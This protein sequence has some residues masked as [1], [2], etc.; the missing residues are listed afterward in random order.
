[1]YVIAVQLA[2]DYFGEPSS[3]WLYATHNI[4]FLGP[5]KNAKTFSSVQEALQWWDKHAENLSLHKCDI[6][7][8]NIYKKTY[9]KIQQ[10]EVKAK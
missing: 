2:V 4:P 3:S 7:T 6:S 10:L 8:L 5:E 1:M 9:Q